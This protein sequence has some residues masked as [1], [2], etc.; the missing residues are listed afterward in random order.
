VDD[1]RP[2]RR[3]ERGSKLSA[4]ARAKSWNSPIFAYFGC[5]TAVAQTKVR[6]V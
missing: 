6:C 3:R 2:A 5:G 4:D 1:R